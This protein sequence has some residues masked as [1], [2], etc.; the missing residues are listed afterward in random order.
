MRCSAT[1]AIARIA[2]L[3]YRGVELMADRPHAWPADA[4][5]RKLEAI[6]SALARHGLEIS[7]L[8]AFMMNAV[9]DPRHV[10]WHPSWIER[11]EA[12]R[13]IRLQHTEDA[14]RM[15][16]RLGAPCITTE[17]G[18]PLEPDMTR[19]W[20]TEVFV[21]G[22][23][24][25]LRVAEE[26]GVLLLVE[27]EP[28]LLIENTE[29]CLDLCARMA[30]PAFGVNFDIGHLFCVG[31]DLPESV[32]RLSP[33]IRHYH[34]EDIAASRIHHHLV[35]GEGAID[36][37]GVFDAIGRSGY[38]GWITVELYPEVDDPD[39]AGDRARRRLDPPLRQTL[40]STRRP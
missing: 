5:P 1:E 3:G 32:E 40:E 6:R 8:N 21:K 18:G 29:Q 4:T 27:P 35:P 39:G 9:G 33:F 19:E 2:A 26:V 28:G 22:L 31:D 25:V 38:D 37:A 24:R 15:A 30:S 13:E 7:N 16:A 11:D 10:Y 20:A 34:V 14:L 12:L 36:F 23:N 17:P